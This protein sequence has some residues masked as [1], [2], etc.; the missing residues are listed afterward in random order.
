MFIDEDGDKAHEFYE[1][2]PVPGKSHTTAMERK[3]VNLRPEV[4]SSIFSIVIIFLSNLML[5]LCNKQ[6]MVRYENPRL[7]VD[8]PILM[9]SPVDGK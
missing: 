7:H 8:F 5:K 1:E 4:N 9:Y 6:G 3:L 2:V